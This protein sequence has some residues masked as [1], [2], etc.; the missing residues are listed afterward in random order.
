MESKKAVF[1]LDSSTI[2]SHK[3]FRERFDLMKKLSVEILTIP[4]LIEQLQIYDKNIP[5]TM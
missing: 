5:V 4:E 3:E 2:L 1:T